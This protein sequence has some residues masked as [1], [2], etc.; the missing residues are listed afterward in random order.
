MTNKDKY[1]EVFCNFFF[2]A[3]LSQNFVWNFH[4]KLSYQFSSVVMPS[5][6]YP[7]L[8]FQRWVKISRN[9]PIFM[10]G[11][12]WK[13]NNVHERSQ[14][15]LTLTSF[16]IEHIFPCW[17]MLRPNAP[18]LFSTLKLPCII[19]KMLINVSDLKA[20]TRKKC[21]EIPKFSWNFMKLPKIPLWNFFRLQK[22]KFYHRTYPHPP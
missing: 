7:V 19:D 9:L 13:F 14:S 2:S 22:L 8:L 17:L 20:N 3:T 21:E 5:C 6:H 4:L 11:S 10:K 18:R 16:Q 12:C 15:C 1:Y